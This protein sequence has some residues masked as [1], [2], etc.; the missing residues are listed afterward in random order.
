MYSKHACPSCAYPVPDPSQPKSPFRCNKTVYRS[1]QHSWRQCAR[2]ISRGKI[3]A[4]SWYHEK[5]NDP[6]ENK[7][8]EK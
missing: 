3:V 7:S 4:L 8:K 6:K 2:G 5:M 1:A